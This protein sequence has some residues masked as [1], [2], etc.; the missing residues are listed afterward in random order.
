MYVLHVLH[1]LYSKLK[2]QP[3]GQTQELEILNQKLIDIVR[4]NL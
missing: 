4:I 2:L 3:H 1:A